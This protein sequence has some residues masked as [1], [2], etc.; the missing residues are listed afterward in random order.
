MRQ[1]TGPTPQKASQELIPEVF[2]GQEVAVLKRCH[3][4]QLEKDKTWQY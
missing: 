2:A 3:I 4:K 1:A